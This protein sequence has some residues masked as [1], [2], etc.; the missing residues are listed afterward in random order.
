MLFCPLPDIHDFCV[1][2]HIEC[3]ERD[4]ASCAPLVANASRITIE[5]ETLRDSFL[6]YHRDLLLG[7]EEI[8]QSSYEDGE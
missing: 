8:I 4:I 7:E 3:T 6:A 2:A 1:L 5:W